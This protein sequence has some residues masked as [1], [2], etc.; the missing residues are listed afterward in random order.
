VF[1]V[2]RAIK[3][4]SL[5]CSQ[6]GYDLTGTAI[7]GSCPECGTSVW[8]TI[9][10]LMPKASALLPANEH[11]TVC[12]ALGMMSACIP[13]V[14]VLAIVMGVISKREIAQGNFRPS[15]RISADVGLLLGCISTI[16]YVMILIGNLG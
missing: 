2:D 16:F 14:G 6:C 4:S 5:K 10:A 1:V 3:P 15:S 8:Q 12:L 11:A 13:F 7:G 9:D